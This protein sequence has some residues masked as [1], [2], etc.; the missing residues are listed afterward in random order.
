MTTSINFFRIE[1]LIM[2]PV[3]YVL[4]YILGNRSHSI[5]E[6]LKK[7][8]KMAENEHNNQQANDT[9]FEKPDRLRRLINPF[10]KSQFFVKLTSNRRRWSHVFPES[11]QLNNTIRS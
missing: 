10:D 3:F 11:M 6:C 4:I 5:D 1:T 2:L 9:T 8:E 7:Y